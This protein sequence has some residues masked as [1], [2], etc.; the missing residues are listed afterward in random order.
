[1]GWEFAGGGVTDCD[2]LAL[3]CPQADNG[4]SINPQTSAQ[5]S[6]FINRS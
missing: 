2:S 6:F 4:T 1:M 3:L 5:M